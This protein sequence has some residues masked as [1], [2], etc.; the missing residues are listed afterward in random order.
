LRRE[1]PRFAEF[2][3]SAEDKYKAREIIWDILQTYDMHAYIDVKPWDLYKQD[4][5]I[6]EE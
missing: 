2:A 3:G 4:L 1:L 5:Q 6:G